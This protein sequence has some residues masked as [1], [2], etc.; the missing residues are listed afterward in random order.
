MNDHLLSLI[1]PSMFGIFIF[2][3]GRSKG[4]KAHW[5]M[6]AAVAAATRS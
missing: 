1:P 5:A 3:S 4:M 6:V 2:S